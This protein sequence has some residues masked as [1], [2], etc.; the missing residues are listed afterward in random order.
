MQRSAV[1]GNLPV[2]LEPHEDEETLCEWDESRLAGQRASL[3][4]VH[5]DVLRIRCSAHT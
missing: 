2:R 1:L 4:A 3:C 5:R